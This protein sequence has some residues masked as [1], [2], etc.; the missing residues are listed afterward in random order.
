ML[1]GIPQECFEYGLGNHSAL[2]WV[3]DQYQVSTDKRNGIE[4]GSNL[5][6]DS[7]S[8]IEYTRIWLA[9]SFLQLASPLR[10]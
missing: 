7:W 2:G 10:L 5:L 8:I 4:S 1:K 9:A 3:I 6:D